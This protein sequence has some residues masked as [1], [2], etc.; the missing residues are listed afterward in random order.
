MSDKQ[1]TLRLPPDLRPAI[2][3]HLESLR[4]GFIARG[5]GGRMGFGERPA[6]IVIDLAKAWMDKN[7][8]G[9]GTDLESVVEETCQLLH[10]AREAEIPI[11]FTTV[12][13]SEDDPVAPNRLKHTR[14]EH[15]APGSEGTELD[16]RLRRRPS[17]K[18]IVKKYASCFQGT[19]LHEMLTGLRV[20]TLI[21]TGCSTSHCVYATCRDASASFRVIVPEEAVGDRCELSHL[22]YLLDIDMGL[23]DTMPAREVLT[24]LQRHRP[25]LATQAGGSREKRRR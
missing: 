7:S 4:Q 14:N 15:G 24:Y 17:E 16:P 11:F 5:W 22:V 21:V 2:Q 23:G 10:A 20:D 9:I 12:A 13:F 8:P 3:A 19:D 6:L 18:L 1:G 25:P